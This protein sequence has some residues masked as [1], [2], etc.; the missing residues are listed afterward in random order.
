MNLYDGKGATHVRRVCVEGWKLC[1]QK[2]EEEQVAGR[3]G[4]TFPPHP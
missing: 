4:C 1:E 3:V 2:R